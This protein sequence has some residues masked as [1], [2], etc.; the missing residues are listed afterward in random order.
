MI[1]PQVT[2]FGRGSPL[3]VQSPTYKVRIERII[4]FHGAILFCLQLWLRFLSKI[5]VSSRNL[6]TYCLVIDMNLQGWGWLESMYYPISWPKVTP[7]Y[8]FKGLLVNESMWCFYVRPIVAEISVNIIAK[9]FCFHFTNQKSTKSSKT[10]S[11]TLILLHGKARNRS[12]QLMEVGLNV[13]EVQYFFIH[14]VR[15]GS[16]SLPDCRAVMIKLFREWL[17]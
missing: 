16:E 17:F 11:Y 9:N 6:S 3:W 12:W 10:N 1:G 7:D 15:S 5:Y 13:A 8:G 14:R 2:L 4:N